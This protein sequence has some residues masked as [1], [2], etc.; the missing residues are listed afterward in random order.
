MVKND[1]FRLENFQIILLL[2]LLYCTVFYKKHLH[3]QYSVQLTT[4][5]NT[6]LFLIRILTKLIRNHFLF[7]ILL[8]ASFFLHKLKL[9]VFQK[10]SD[11]KFPQ[12][13]RKIQRILDDFFS[14]E[15]NMVT[16]LSLDSSSEW[17]SLY[18]LV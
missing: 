1:C 8:F 18:C 16:I 6:H 17:F 14:G 4:P 10:Q 9:M 12:I 3:Q 5:S 15:V 13:S 11:S 2:C 7:I